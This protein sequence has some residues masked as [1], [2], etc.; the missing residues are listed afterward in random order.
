VLPGKRHRCRV[1]ELRVGDLSAVGRVEERP[2]S[3]ER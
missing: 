3:V 2:H 1:G